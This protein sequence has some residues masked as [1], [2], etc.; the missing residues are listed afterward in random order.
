MITFLFFSFFSFTRPCAKPSAACQHVCIVCHPL[1]CSRASWVTAGGAAHTHLIIWCY[2]CYILHPVVLVARKKT[3]CVRFVCT[4]CY[5]GTELYRRGQNSGVMT[6]QHAISNPSDERSWCSVREMMENR[7][8]N[9]GLV[10]YLLH[11]NVD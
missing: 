3:R 5:I 9:K 11:E 4:L 10:H 8:Q 6:K 1:G 2:Y 7:V